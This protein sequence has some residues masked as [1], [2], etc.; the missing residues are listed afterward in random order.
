[1]SLYA[2]TAAPFGGTPFVAPFIETET[3]ETRPPSEIGGTFSVWVAGAS[4]PRLNDQAAAS[5]VRRSSW[6]PASRGNAAANAYVPSDGELNDFRSRNQPWDSWAQYVTGRPGIPGATTDE[7]L[8]WA[9]WKWGLDELL[10]RAQAAHESSWRQSAIGDRPS[11]G[12]DDAGKECC[13]F[14]LMQIKDHRPNLSIVHPGTYPL[15]KL[16]TAFNVDWAGGF[17]RN[18]R[19]GR[20]SGSENGMLSWYFSGSSCDV[21]TYYNSVRSHLANRTWLTY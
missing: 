11:G 8:Q 3:G 19:A 5:R 2:V 13:S 9:A 21:P 14:G 12:L 20:C 15:S 4:S 1:M 10:L 7:L 18:I 6:E 16:S 17:L